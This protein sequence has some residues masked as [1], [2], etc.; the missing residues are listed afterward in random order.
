MFCGEGN[1][2]PLQ[3]SCLENPRDGGAWWAAVSGI[4]QSQMQLKRLSNVDV[5]RREIT[6]PRSFASIAFTFTVISPRELNKPSD[7]CVI[8]FKTHQVFPLEMY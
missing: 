5:L 2:T 1:G 6:S 7:N 8:D 4:T 3:C